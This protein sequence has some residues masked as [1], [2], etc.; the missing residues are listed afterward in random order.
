MFGANKFE[1]LLNTVT[2]SAAVRSGLL[3]ILFYLEF[4]IHEEAKS[5]DKIEHFDV[6]THKYLNTYIYITQTLETQNK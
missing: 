4:S 2:R 5:T 3:N 1:T 6:L